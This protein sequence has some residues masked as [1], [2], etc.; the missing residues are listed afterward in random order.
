LEWADYP[1]CGCVPK[2][3]QNPESDKPSPK[4]SE[5]PEGGCNFQ[6]RLEEC[7]RQ[8][9]SA[10]SNCDADTDSGISAARDSLK[11]I[12]VGLSQQV[13]A[14]N[15]CS[16]LAKGLGAANAA[17]AAFTGVC[18]DTRTTCV[19]T[20]SSLRNALERDGA[21]CYGG[22][23]SAPAL[24][25]IRADVREFLDTCNAL[26]TKI[27]QGVAAVNN[28]IGSLQ[29][30]QSCAN[31]LDVGLLYCKQNPTAI[32]CDTSTDCNNAVI[33]NSS[34]ICYCSKGLPPSDPRYSTCNIAVNKSS[35]TGTDSGNVAA[36][37][38][39]LTGGTNGGINTDDLMDTS[40]KGDPNWKKGNTSGEDPGGSKGGRP[41]QDGT[42]G[43]PGGPDGGGGA[44]GAANQM[45]VNSGF[46]GGAGG[47]SGGGFYGGG[48]GGGAAGGRGGSAENGGRGPDLRQFLPGGKYDPKARRG[49]AGLSGPDGITGPYSNIWQKIQNRYQAERVKL[50]P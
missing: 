21:A 40:W 14:Q 36:V 4:T 13:S 3:A 18:S 25:Q 42:A 38:G 50:I 6:A 11:T 44:G 23:A 45:A 34:P 1:T 49:I 41:L 26:D 28:T 10:N 43:N 29:G 47:G 48:G 32:G 2:Q 33:A 5:D 16:G 31:Q 7:K 27:Q 19:N 12:A 20:C 46:R 39:G 17:V 15:A 30:A 35:G 37:G 24:A 9:D 22:N 8:R